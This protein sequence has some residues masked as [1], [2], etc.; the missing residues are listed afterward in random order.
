MKTSKILLCVSVSTGALV[1]F[2]CA[3][4]NEK[5]SQVSQAIKVEY[6]NMQAQNVAESPTSGIDGNV[7]DSNENV[8]AEQGTNQPTHNLDTIQ[9]QPQIDSQ[10]QMAKLSIEELRNKYFVAYNS[11]TPDGQKLA[12]ECIAVMIE[13]VGQQYLQSKTLD[14]L[15]AN[16]E[17]LQFAYG[18]GNQEMMEKCRT[19]F[20]QEQV[21]RERIQKA[22]NDEK[23]VQYLE[24][25]FAEIDGMTDGEMLL[26]KMYNG[27]YPYGLDQETK[28][29]VISHCREKLLATGY[30]WGEIAVIGQYIAKGEMK[31]VVNQ[32]TQ[33]VFEQAPNNDRSKFIASMQQE[34][35]QGIAACSWL[36]GSQDGEDMGRGFNFLEA[37]LKKEAE[38]EVAN[39]RDNNE[40]AYPNAKICD[41][42]VALYKSYYSG[43]NRKIIETDFQK[44]P[45]KV[46]DT[47]GFYA[48]SIGQDYINGD[49]KTTPEVD[50]I[51]AQESLE[52]QEAVLVC[53]QIVIPSPDVTMNDLIEK[54]AKILGIE[55]PVIKREPRKG[56][57]YDQYFEI[58][59]Y[60]VT[61]EMSK[62]GQTVKLAGIDAIIDYSEA[63]NKLAEGLKKYAR[64]RAEET[65]NQYRRKT[66]QYFDD[67]QVEAYKKLY[68]IC[69]DAQTK[70]EEAKKQMKKDNMLDF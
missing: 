59:L 55:K 62:N 53:V 14:E 17:N 35:Y 67:N 33:K 27:D 2:S 30:V 31:D 29:K 22:E 25:T 23:I 5:L 54:Y 69:I 40:F 57:A 46:Y 9:K 66:I 41:S 48:T 16:E 39:N 7:Q 26:K 18:H 45:S 58:K 12:L 44:K 42:K 47:L 11:N 20:G 38:K 56:G 19:F 60:D 52:S 3:N 6:N 61:C 1:M 70:A 8:S 65:K 28:N 24:K 21:I 64:Q 37:E 43:M 36:R 10:E 4:I 13:K 49:N 34:F 63:Y 51:F 50:F 32:L 15:K 68:R